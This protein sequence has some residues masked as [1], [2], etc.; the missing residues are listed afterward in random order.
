MR[1]QTA[2]KRILVITILF[3]LLTWAGA[4]MFYFS[5]ESKKI[6]A[7]NLAGEITLKNNQKDEIK[8]L[9]RD[10]QNLKDDLEKI[11]NH[12]VGSS[13]DKVADFLKT[14][15][16]ISEKS[17]TELDID[18]IDIAPLADKQLAEQFE[19]LNL[20]LQITGSW[21]SVFL[22]L[23]LIENLPQKI[24]VKNLGLSVLENLEETTGGAE[25]SGRLVLS[26]EKFK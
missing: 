14:I 15:E 2:I 26:T 21:N 23:G 4:F 13:Q 12:I 17:G 25:W 5:I 19:E 24:E 11:D 6:A 1:K 3:A 7:G 8:A 16:K 20:T 22:F 18:S 9:S 10:I